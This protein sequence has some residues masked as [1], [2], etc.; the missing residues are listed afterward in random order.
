MAGTLIVALLLRRGALGSIRCMR[1]S[2]RVCQSQSRHKRPNATNAPDGTP[3][4]F[5]S[6][7]RAQPTRSAGCTFS[8]YASVG[9]HAIPPTEA[10]PSILKYGSRDEGK[11]ERSPDKGYR[12]AK[13]E[14]S[15]T[16]WEERKV[17]GRGE[18]VKQP[19]TTTRG[20]GP[21]RGS[22]DRGGG[23]WRPFGRRAPLS[24]KRLINDRADTVATWP[25]FR[26]PATAAA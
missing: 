7:E 3:C 20:I 21:R 4:S 5:R 6:I 10:P 8:R 19:D 23:G 18:S 14:E 2:L 13:S 16:S 24:A 26:W 22:S 15:V 9:I 11:S 25:T 17:L 1:R 12:A